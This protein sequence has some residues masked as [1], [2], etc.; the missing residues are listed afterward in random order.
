VPITIAAALTHCKAVSNEGYNAAATAAVIAKQL[1]DAKIDV[2]DTPLLNMDAAS[3]NI[4]TANSDAF[5]T[6]WHR[7]REQMS[8]WTCMSTRTCTCNQ[9]YVGRRVRICACLRLQ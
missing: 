2:R 7:Q 5:Q 8:A 3:V 4:A 9:A 6:G 1:E